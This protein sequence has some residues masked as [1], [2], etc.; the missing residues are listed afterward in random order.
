MLSS[1]FLILQR[2]LMVLVVLFMSRFVSL[3]VLTCSDFLAYALGVAAFAC[4]FF[5]KSAMR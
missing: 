1:F 3:H 5:P 2:H 4:N